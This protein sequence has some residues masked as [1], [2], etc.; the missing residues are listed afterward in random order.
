MLQFT[1]LQLSGITHGITEKGDKPPDGVVMGEQVHKNVLQWVKERPSG[2]VRG[3]D[4]LATREKGI[5]LAVRVADCVPILFADEKAGVVGVIHAG[6]RGAALEVTR[7]AIEGLK[8]R[9]DNLKV[10]I[11]P[12]I[13]PGRFE[14]GAE[15]AG[16]FS[17]SLVT[18][19]KEKEGV[20]HV[21]LWQSAID[22]CIAA[23]VKER[24]IEVI[25]KCTYDSEDLYS[26]RAGDR[27]ERNIAYIRFD[28]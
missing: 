6:W 25:R 15:V 27:E 20:F 1:N 12:C 24:N 4:A 21:D 9:P 11:G 13:S 8:M 26:F 3:A 28:G 10:G 22:Q 18:E 23:G 7:K 17:S 14:V 19:S 2:M 5:T 16:Q